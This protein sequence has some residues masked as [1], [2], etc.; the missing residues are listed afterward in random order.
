ML[1]F[2]P[3]RK[4]RKSPGETYDV[5]FFLGTS[6]NNFR[7]GTGTVNVSVDGVPH[8]YNLSTT[9]LDWEWN[10]FG[11]QYFASTHNTRRRR[12]RIHRHLHRLNNFTKYA[13]ALSLRSVPG[14]GKRR[15]MRLKTVRG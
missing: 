13:L 1:F 9:S 3:C 15:F 12:R 6:C 10:P 7:D 2:C 14:G 11:F 4:L 8:S 5:S